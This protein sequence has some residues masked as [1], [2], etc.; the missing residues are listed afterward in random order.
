VLEFIIGFGIAGTGFGVVLAVVGRAA[1]DAHRSMALGIAT[2]AGSGGQVI[3]APA[4]EFLMR[5]MPWQAVFLVF[6]LTILAVLLT[7][8]MFRTTR[9]AN[10]RTLEESL[11][12]TLNRAFADP[13]Y[14]LIFAGFFSCGYQLALITAHFPAFVTE[15]CSSVSPTSLLHALGFN[16][17]AALG[18]LAISVIGL[19][20]IVGTLLAGHLG[21]FY[22]RK[23]LLAL[24]YA[25]RTVST[26]IFVM[27]PITPTS[28]LLFSVAMGVLWLAT[29]PLTS[30]LIAHIYGLKYMGTLYGIIFFSHQVGGFLGV[31]LGGTLYDR[32]GN[33]DM[34]WWIGIAVAA[35]SA[36]VHLPINEKPLM[37][38]LSSP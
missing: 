34:V 19:A 23:Y 33:Y 35:F 22:S 2:A 3:G 5:I 26:L 1:S 31:W 14:S 16:S 27:L 24:I 10:R 13:S 20:N 11:G 8:P 17:T 12:K 7:L 37:H 29:V 28:V 18:A 25:L 38:R 30:G 32:H 9:V 36:L 21:R 4:A 6:A 15:F